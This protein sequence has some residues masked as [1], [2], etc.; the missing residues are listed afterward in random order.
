MKQLK[1]LFF[2]A[3][4]SLLLASCGKDPVQYKL[5]VSADTLVF[6]GIDTVRLTV[7]TDNPERR[8]FYVNA[9]YEWVIYYPSS[10]SI[11]KGEPVTLTLCSTLDDPM[12]DIIED[13][14][15]ISTAYDNK[16]VKLIGLPEDYTNYTLPEALF[17]PENVNDNT[18]RINNYGN[19]TLEYSIAASNSFISVSPTSGQIAMMQHANVN[20]SIDRENLLNVTHPALY[21]TIDGTV[22]TVPI[23]LEKK[24]MLPNDVVD[25]EYSKATNLLVYVAG[26]AT[27]NIYHPDT[28]ELS[29][30]AL[31]YVPTCVSLSPD[32]TK[33]VAGHDAHVTYVDLMTESVLTVN[34]VSCDA[35]DIVLTDSGWTYVF[36]RRDQWSRI[37]CLNVSNENASVTQHTGNLIYAGTRGKLHPSGKYIYG[38]DNGLSPADIEKYDIQGGTAQYLYDSPYHGDY[39]MGGDLWFEE[40]GER[41]FT[42]AGTVF[43]TSETQSSDM[44]YNGKIQFQSDY[45][46]IL[47]LDQL[48]RNHELYFVTKAYNYWYDEVADPYVYIYN[49]DNLTYKEKIRIEDY[50]VATGDNYDIYEASPRF[51]F[52]HSNGEQLYVITKAVGSGLAHEWAIQTIDR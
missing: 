18:L 1:H 19:T 11:A 16:T 2:L 46:S 3:A 52:A 47:W 21:V 31:S 45:G 8:D 51:V 22:D 6:K 14:L 32:G 29:S 42:R 41:L 37:F 33:A 4:A 26:D 10:G 27:L 15:Y 28:R 23:V 13:F 40:S 43:K 24:L 49:S 35:L 50:C 5:S 30:V 20:V 17:F 39:S 38:A 44:I 25:A 9:P 48:D 7:S 36:P 12:A 34:S